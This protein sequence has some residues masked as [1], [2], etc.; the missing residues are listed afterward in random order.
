MLRCIDLLT[1]LQEWEERESATKARDEQLQ[2]QLQELETAKRE[3]NMLLERFR[4][5]EHSSKQ[6][7]D[8]L[9]DKYEEARQ[10][11]VQFTIEHQN[12]VPLAKY[13]RA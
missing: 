13:G 8:R 7:L 11:L 3:M 1:N 10:Q 4:L 2:M 6:S 9:M 12:D 5:D